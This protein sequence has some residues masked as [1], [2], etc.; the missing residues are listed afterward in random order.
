[1]ANSLIPEEIHARLDA[2]VNA[3]M[4]MQQPPASPQDVAFILSSVVACCI[5]VYRDNSVELD[6]VYEDFRACL[7]LVIAN[8]HI[9]AAARAA[10]A[11]GKYATVRDLEELKLPATSSGPIHSAAWYNA[12][13]EPEEK[14][15]Q[16]V[17]QFLDAIEE[18]MRVFVATY[19]WPVWQPPAGVKGDVAQHLASLKL[20]EVDGRPSLLL[21]NL[22][23][24]S[25]DDETL[26][27]VKDVFSSRGGHK[28]FLVNTSGS[29]KTRILLE[30]LCLEWGFYFTSDFQRDSL[31]SCDLNRGITE[32]SSR[33]SPGFEQAFIDNRAVADRRFRQ[34]LTARFLIFRLFLK[35]AENMLPGLSHVLKRRWLYL[36]LKPEALNGKDVFD[37][38]SGI[39]H[40]ACDGY[41]RSLD[42][43]SGS[44]L[45]RSIGA[46]KLTVVV[47]EAQFAAAQL[48]DAFLLDDDVGLR[49]ALRRIVSVWETQAMPDT[50]IIVSGT[51]PSI[52]AVV[53]T[54]GSSFLKIPEPYRTCCDT[55]FFDKPGCQEK[56]IRRYVP[57]SYLS[58]PSGIALLRRAWHWLRGRH[59]FTATFITLLIEDGFSSPHRILDSYITLV[60]ES[61]PADGGELVKDEPDPLNVNASSSFDLYKLEGDPAMMKEIHGSLVACTMRSTPLVFGSEQHRIVE[62]GLARTTLTDCVPQITI[63][64]PLA[65]L[66]TATW[67]DTRPGFTSFAAMEDTLRGTP[68]RGKGFENYIAYYLSHA[69]TLATPLTAIF[70]FVGDTPS[71]AHKPAEL[72]ALSLDNGVYEV[73]PVYR[74]KCESYTAS[75]AW[76]IQA[77][78]PAGTLQWLWNPHSVPFCFFD[79][80]M[81]SDIGCFIRLCDGTL[82]LMVVQ[83]R[84]HLENIWPKGEVFG[85]VATVT[86]S[87]FYI[88]K[89]GDAQTPL[90]PQVHERLAQIGTPLPP[91]TERP[92]KG[93][94]NV[95]R[96]VVPCPGEPAALERL[97][98]DD[99]D[100][101]LA[102]L[103]LERCMREMDDNGV[104][105]GFLKAAEGKARLKR[106]FA[107]N[108][109][110][111]ARMAALKKMKASAKE[112]PKKLAGAKKG[113]REKLKGLK[114][115]ATNGIALKRSERLKKPKK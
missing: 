99:D 3:E 109:P 96:V 74:T 54:W 32:F 6:P 90:L 71:W 15:V 35:V 58:T 30:G 53:K 100:H 73:S 7:K 106:R 83:T 14:T 107:N 69:I 2:A 49:P 68:G 72:V 4:C 80:Y 108:K 43:L 33:Q 12:V 67:F 110:T 64:E 18:K 105:K 85:T 16:A 84:C 76:G 13:R 94:Y 86:P 65:L 95:M 56:Y 50:S 115:V 77:N 62:W 91:G 22:G 102:T 28:T 112:G 37:T 1:M 27:R 23:S 41:L 34:I 66:A 103:N 87:Q 17:N 63:D 59:E 57:A 92:T 40:N 29:G 101:P 88:D 97:L 89:N 81:G 11:Q 36:Q 47:D 98:D 44:L 20:P 78:D 52:R 46:K 10:Y 24:L 19:E 26:D 45:L 114:G 25:P 60:T 93:R 31:G 42:D 111:G 79:A 75:A 38:L 55:G 113:A 39:L 9:A 21:H 70:D 51:S 61:V 8:P 5:N 82:L 104:L 48:S